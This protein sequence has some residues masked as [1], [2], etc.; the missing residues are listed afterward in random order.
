MDD[1]QRLVQRQISR[2]YRGVGCIAPDGVGAGGEPS[3]GTDSDVPRDGE[4]PASHQ[5]GTKIAG[6]AGG[7]PEGDCR[8]GIAKYPDGTRGCI[9]ARSQRAALNG[10]RARVGVGTRKR[11]DTCPGA[12]HS[13]ATGG[14]PGDDTR[15]RDAAVGC[16]IQGQQDI[17]GIGNGTT[18]GQQAGGVVRERLRCAKCDGEV[19]TAY[20]RSLRTRIHHDA[21]GANRQRLRTGGSQSVAGRRGDAQFQTVHRDRSPEIHR[22]THA[23]AA[24]HDR[25]RGRCRNIGCGKQRIEKRQGTLIRPGSRT[26]GGTIGRGGVTVPRDGRRTAPGGTGGNRRAKGEGGCEPAK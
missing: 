8:H 23:A 9:S 16:R 19:R 2:E 14:R 11:H 4:T 21:A 10:R 13:H 12:G 6:D 7:V 5:G 24:E 15:E 3:V 22:A 26:I 1:A 17:T 18:D 20:R 25:V